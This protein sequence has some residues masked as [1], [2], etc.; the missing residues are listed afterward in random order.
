MRGSERSR[1]DVRPLHIV[2]ISDTPHRPPCYRLIRPT[3]LRFSFSAP[4]QT[5]LA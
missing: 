2:A 1:T 3:L 4:D 5:G